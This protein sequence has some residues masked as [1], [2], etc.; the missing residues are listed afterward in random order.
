MLWLFSE[1]RCLQWTCQLC[2]TSEIASVQRNFKSGEGK[3]A[4]AGCIGYHGDIG[5]LRVACFESHRK[6]MEVTEEKILCGTSAS[7]YQ[8]MLC[9]GWDHS[10]HAHQGSGIAS[11]TLQEQFSSVYFEVAAGA[12]EAGVSRALHHCLKADVGPHNEKWSFLF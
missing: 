11:M 4:E 3:R 6:R 12:K 9:V 7:T 5:A 1:A 2:S 10:R 8:T